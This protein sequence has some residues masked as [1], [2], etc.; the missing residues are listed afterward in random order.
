[1]EP[2][3]Y[4]LA[5]RPRRQEWA[6]QL[7]ENG[8]LYITSR[9]CLK[10]SG[11]RLSGRIGSYEMSAETYFELDEPHDW[12]YVDHLLRSRMRTDDALA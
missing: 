11:S 2:E 3:N 12:R 8:A 7:V 4:D 6:G 1:M 9:L 5:R 10:E